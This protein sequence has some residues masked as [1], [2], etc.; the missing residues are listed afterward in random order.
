[1]PG[2]LES[3]VTGRHHEAGVAAAQAVAE[4]LVELR[5]LAQSRRRRE[6]SGTHGP[7]PGYGVRRLRPLARRAFTTWRPRL[8]A[9][10][11]RKPW[12]FLRRPFLGWYVLFMTLRSDEACDS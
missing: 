10:R 9:M 11:A 12:V 1:E 8:V 2:A 5:R 6:G 7:C 4:H 3:V